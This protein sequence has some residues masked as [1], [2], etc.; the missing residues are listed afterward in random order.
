MTSTPPFPVDD[1]ALDRFLM[2]LLAARSL[3]TEEAAAAALLEDELR[4]LGFTVDVDKL[5]NVVG[6]RTFGPGPTVLIDTHLD[7][8]PVGDAAEWSRDPAGEIADG[9]VYGRGAVDMKGPIAACVHGVASLAGSAVAGTVVISGGVTEELVEGAAAI[10]VAETVKPDYVVI[11]EPSRRRIARGQRGRAEL[12][13]E[14]EG[15][16]CH[17]A[18]PDAGINAVEVMSD[19]LRALRDLKPSTDAVLGDGI[20][21][22]TDIRSDPYPSLSVVPE[23]CTATLDRRTLVDEGATDIVA[24]VQQIVDQITERWGTRGAVRIA[25]D[26]FTTYTG[27]TLRA[28][29]FAPA[30]LMDEDSV[31]IGRATAGLKTAGLD[32]VVGHYKFCTNGSATAGALGIPT[33]GFGPGDESQAHTVD[34]SIELADLHL[35]A[36]GYA[37]IVSALLEAA[38]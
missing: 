33:I 18:Y 17:S 19:V 22:V 6:S 35:G 37:A 27:V 8:V 31:I 9:R 1:D 15:R 5:G 13:I 36:Q 30:W 29:N 34:E 14:V 10:G 2:R 28:P 38:G 32:A 3:S 26:V 12:I 25:E 16:S 7:T 20:L 24:P 4:Q 21:V 11:C 23:R